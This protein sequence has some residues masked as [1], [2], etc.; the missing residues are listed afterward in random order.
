MGQRFSLRPE[1]AGRWLAHLAEAERAR[2]RAAPVIF[3]PFSLL[4]LSKGVANPLALLGPLTD[5]YA[6]LLSTL[7]GAGATEVQLDEPGFTRKREWTCFRSY[8]RKR[9]LWT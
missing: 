9:A 5:V 1:S 7:A 2:R 6:E 8:A 3:G 4:S